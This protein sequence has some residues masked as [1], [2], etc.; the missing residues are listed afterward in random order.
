[1]EPGNPEYQA[2]LQEMTSGGQTELAKQMTARAAALRNKKRL[3]NV[4]SLAGRDPALAL[5]GEEI[6]LRLLQADGSKRAW[7]GYVTESLQ[8]GADGGWARLNAGEKPVSAHEYFMTNPSLSGRGS[9]LKGTPR[10]PRQ[11]R[12]MQD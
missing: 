5:T 1:M 11:D 9:A 4:L 7:H 2:F 10:R 3:D 6:T 12:V 8:L